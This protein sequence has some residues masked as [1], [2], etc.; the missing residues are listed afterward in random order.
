[1]KVTS[2]KKGNVCTLTVEG[3]IDTLTAPE[4][5]Q[6]VKAK[7]PGCDKM[8]FDFSNVEYITSAGLR[9]LVFAQRELM[10]KDGVV[11]KGANKEIENIFTMTGLNKVLTIK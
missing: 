6:E 8:V 4:L 10:K 9:V 3:R 7:L 1:M 5:E 11:V 2:T